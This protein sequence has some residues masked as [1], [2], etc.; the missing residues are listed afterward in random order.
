MVQTAERAAGMLAERGVSAHVLDLRTLVPLDV[1]GIVAAV[2]RT[3]RVIVAHE[4]PLTAGFGAEV[5]ATINEEA[6]YSLE[7]PIRRVTAPDTPYPLAGVEDFYVPRAEDLVAAAL[8][9]MGAS[10]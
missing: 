5:V 8:E 7:A 9:V 1:D 4:A 6:F 10:A 3:G 2:E